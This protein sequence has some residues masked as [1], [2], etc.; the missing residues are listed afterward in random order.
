MRT[1]TLREAR[2]LLP[3]VVRITARHREEMEHVWSALGLRS[4]PFETAEAHARLD[5]LRD[6]WYREMR[7]PGALPRRL[8]EVNFDTGD[9]YY[10]SWRI[11]EPDIGFVCRDPYARVVARVAIPA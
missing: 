10:Y 1:F 9:G 8:W 11:G 6:S 5:R 2:R 7:A 4:T 3:H